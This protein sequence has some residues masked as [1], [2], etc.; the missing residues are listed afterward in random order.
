[1]WAA[2]HP[3]GQAKRAATAVETAA[4][5]W[6]APSPLRRAGLE[7]VLF[8]VKAGWACLFAGALLAAVL[9]TFWLYPAN[10]SLAR[11]DFLL[12]L[13]LGLQ[14]A[15]VALRL[16]RPREVLVILIFHVVGTVMEVFKT[17]QGSWIYPEASL[18]RIGD[19]P[20]FSGF[21][22]AGVGSYLAR[23]TRLLD[24]RYT[25]HPP[26]WAVGLLA[27]AAYA[28]FFTHHFVWDGRWVLIGA[29]AL[30]F[31]RTTVWF[32]PDRRWRRMPLLLGL[33]LTA[34]FIW[35]AENVG[36]F[37]AIWVYPAQR[38]AWSPVSWSKFG[39]WYLLLLLSY[40]LTLAVHRPK[41]PEPELGPVSA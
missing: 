41:A 21:M 37:A 20:L 8:G 29:S 10:A 11:Y 28:N 13:A 17:A 5:R 16:E 36:T 38:E 9:L 34:L 22:Y 26:L 4:R 31:A 24:L 14:A 32:R 19:V 39:S 25:R 33:V 15:L 3:Y 27:A 2:A 30:L 23:A 12:L 35:V 18:M 40:A 1:M 6:A 7:L